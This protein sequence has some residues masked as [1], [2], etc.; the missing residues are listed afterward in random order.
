MLNGHELV[1]IK[2]VIR[3]PLLALTTAIL[4]FSTAPSAADGAGGATSI[5]LYDKGL[6]SYYVAG[7]IGGYG[8]IE[9]MVDTGSAYV[10]ISEN[11]IAQLADQNLAKFVHTKSAVLANGG[12]IAIRVYRIAGLRVG[13]RCELRDVDVAVVPGMQRQ[14]LGLNA[15]KMAAPFTISVEPPSLS[16]SHCSIVSAGSSPPESTEA[17]PHANP[18]LAA[19]EAAAR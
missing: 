5:P 19:A 4:V 15:L 12:T 9:F 14:I 17:T 1:Q 7:H 6:A 8:D 18:S 13:D 16:L 11:V 2:V 3:T 10:A